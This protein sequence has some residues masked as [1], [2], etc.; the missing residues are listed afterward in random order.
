MTEDIYDTYRG[1]LERLRG[2]NQYRS[3]QQ[4]SRRPAGVVVSEEG[5]LLNLSSNDYLGMGSD[6]SLLAAFISAP[7]GMLFD[8][9]GMTSSSSRLLTGNSPGYAALEE[10]L[11]SLYDSRA[12]CVFNSGYHVNLGLFP[13]LGG[14]G[15]LFL[16]DR[17]NHAS[18]IDGLRLTGA[19]FRRY[20]HRDYDHLEDLLAST[21]KAYRRTFIVTESVFSMDG[22]LADL[23]R[24]VELKGAYGAMLIVDEAH[25]VGVFGERGLGLCESM[26]VMKEVDVIVGTFGK[27]LASTGAFSVTNDLLKEFLVNTMRPLIFTTAL[28]PAVLQWSRVT[29]RRMTAMERERRELAGLSRRLR[30]ELAARGNDVRGGSQIVPVVAG[31]NDASV[32][33]AARLR[34]KGF[35][36][37]PVRPPTVPPGTARV[38]LSLTAGT[39]WEQIAAIPG[40]V[41]E[42]FS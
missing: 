11:S 14:K 19:D 3:L 39:R 7:A 27:A 24:L 28:P 26:G 37:F 17:L 9:R 18:I 36:V 23:R 30:H 16:S 4:L 22:D 6:E 42:F 25:A 13:A 35:L 21:G 34:S 1:E 15:D 20:R 10:D 33:L 41:E 32:R 8:E 2:R 29:L 12:C 40:L 5:V 38:R 31:D